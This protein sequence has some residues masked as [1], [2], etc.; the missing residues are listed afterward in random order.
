MPYS[1]IQDVPA[2]ADI[3][4]QIRELLPTEAPPGLIAHIVLTRTG[5][6]RYVDVWEN[7]A[8]WERFRDDHVEPAVGKVLAGMGIPH[9]HDDIAVE[10][11]DVIDVWLGG[12]Q[13][14]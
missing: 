13:S 7:E 4:R 2:D 11:V 14:R 8:A 12:S 3:Y 1:F 6:L 10:T 5:G 9:D